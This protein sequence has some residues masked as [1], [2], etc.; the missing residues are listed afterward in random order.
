MPIAWGCYDPEAID[1]QSAFEA[2]ASLQHYDLHVIPV[3][4]WL[5]YNEASNWHEARALRGQADR[6][7]DDVVRQDVSVTPFASL[8]LWVCEGLKFA[9]DIFWVALCGMQC[10]QVQVSEDFSL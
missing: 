6:L 5:R 1:C 10:L 7:V 9:V 2:I 8:N 4:S 3:R